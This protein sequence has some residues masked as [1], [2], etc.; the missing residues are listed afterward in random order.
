MKGRFDYIPFDEQ[1]ADLQAAAK[2]ECTILEGFI[3]NSIMTHPSAD[4]ATKREA[5]IALTELEHVYARIGRAV[6]NLQI[7]RGGSADDAPK[8]S[9][10]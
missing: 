1:S 10:E 9:N 2:D 5:A 3:E 7:A 4:G 8:R 6:R